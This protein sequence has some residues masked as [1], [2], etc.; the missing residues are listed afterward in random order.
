MAG[1][2]PML[3]GEYVG[4]W[5][6]TEASKQHCSLSDPSPTGSTTT[7]QRGLP[8]PGEY[9]RYS[10][11]VLR[12]RNMAQMKEQIKTLEKA[13]PVW[14]SGLSMGLQTKGLWFD[15]Q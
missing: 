10:T 1:D 14:P 5:G 3:T 6:Q 8:Q 15:S 2:T 4:K 9:L 12:Q 13:W 7:Q 11:A